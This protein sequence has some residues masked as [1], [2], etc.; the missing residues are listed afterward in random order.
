MPGPK[1]FDKKVNDRQAAAEKKANDE[2]DAIEARAQA[3]ITGRK[4][5][6]AD[7]RTLTRCITSGRLPATCTGNSLLGGFSQMISSVLPSTTK[8]PAPGP[9]MAGV[10]EGAGNWRLDFIDDGVL[11]NCSFLSPDQHS[12]TLEFKNNHTALIIDTTPKPLVLTLRADGTIV[13]PGPV[14]IDG[15]VASGYTSGND[16][17]ILQ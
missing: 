1:A 6:T 12:Y 10:F 15:V 17:T 14:T 7:E 5:Q 16:P 3:V 8:E 9:E 2:N 13:G 11:V 4:P